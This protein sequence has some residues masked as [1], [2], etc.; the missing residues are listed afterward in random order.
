M[1]GGLQAMLDQSVLLLG[2][3]LDMRLGGIAIYI[4]D[5]RRLAPLVSYVSFV[6][7]FITI[8]QYM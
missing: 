6:I 2:T 3:I 5:L 4:V 8:H 7:K 1:L